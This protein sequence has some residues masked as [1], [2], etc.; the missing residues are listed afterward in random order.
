MQYSSK[1]NY[2]PKINYSSKTGINSTIND[3]LIPQQPEANPVIP[4]EKDDKNSFFQDLRPI[5]QLFS[6]YILTTDDKGL[7]I[8]DQHAAHERIRYEN[9]LDVYR[10]TK[11]A[12]QTLLI[13]E[14]VE[15]TLQEEQ[16]ILAHYE[17][18]YNLGFIL[19]HFGER[20][21]FLV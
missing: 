13:P 7:Y 5:G 12:S 2:N 10:N 1:T 3:N 14:I 20:T 17:E 4:N 9:I 11:T 19:E 8:I 21:Y 18:L 6:T 16:L 15:L